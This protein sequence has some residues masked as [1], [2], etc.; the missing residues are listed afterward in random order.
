MMRVFIVML[1]LTLGCLGETL[2][3]WENG[4]EVEVPDVWLRR[5]MKAA[6][7]K[8]SSDE[9]RMQVEPYF[10]ITHNSQIQRLHDLTKKDG[11]R[12]KSEQDLSINGVPAHEMI[13]FKDGDYKIYYVVMAGERGFLW[14][15]Y[16]ESTDSPAFLE[17]QDIIS[18][19][20]I[21][22]L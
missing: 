3:N 15:V 4:F 17:G 14:T 2:V 21:K 5:D 22:P 11:W 16:S 9:V 8:L 10:G 19:F 7:L 1:S 12:F 20:T 6:G 18:S 13:F